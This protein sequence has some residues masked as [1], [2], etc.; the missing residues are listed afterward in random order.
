MLKPERGD[1]IIIGASRP[2]HLKQNMA[3]LGKGKLPEDVAQAVEE[4]WE[5]SR[6]DAPEYFTLYTAPGRQEGGRPARR[7]R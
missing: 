4:A 7:K 5:I 1:G 6:A 3:F 2:A